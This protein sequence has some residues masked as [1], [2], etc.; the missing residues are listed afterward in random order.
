MRN[1]SLLGLVVLLGCTTAPAKLENIPLVWEPE[2]HPRASAGAA[3]AAFFQTKIK[4]LP[5]TDLRA[6][7]QLIGENREKA[8]ARPVT[9]NADVSAFVTDHFKALLAGAGLT[10]VDSGENAIIQGQ[11]QQF[12]VD[13]AE[14][15][16][17]T[18][19][20]HIVAT[21][22][23]GKTVWDGMTTGE[24]T[25]FGLSYR[26]ENYHQSLSDA[27]S[28]AVT[29]LLQDPGFEAGIAGTH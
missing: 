17:G 2:K 1:L 16:T 18:V 20:L 15:Y 21:D 14:Q 4:V 28:V 22:A 29:F 7:P 19:R 11:I 13:E 5:M 8:P 26:A 27:L 25:R 12:F 6:K 10:L 24:S 9:T 3:P 23:A